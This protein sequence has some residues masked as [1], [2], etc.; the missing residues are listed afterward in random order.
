MLSVH[1]SAYLR[2]FRQRVDGVIG[3][4]LGVAISWL[5]K[6]HLAFLQ[7]P[8]ENVVLMLF[9]HLAISLVYNLGICV[10]IDAATTIFLV[11]WQS[12]RVL[13]A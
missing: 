4:V 6:L 9:L 12:K 13:V 3:L 1:R 7:L 5:S 8:D 11:N 10:G 2:I